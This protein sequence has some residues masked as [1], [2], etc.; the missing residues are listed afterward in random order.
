MS[1]PNNIQITYDMLGQIVKWNKS[2]L[3]LLESICT[4]NVWH[5]DLMNSMSQ[6]VI[7][8]NV[9]LRSMILSFEHFEFMKL[10]M[11]VAVLS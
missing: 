11:V 4:K 7:D 8:S 6:N 9:F 10:K 3:L 2:N 5:L 1:K